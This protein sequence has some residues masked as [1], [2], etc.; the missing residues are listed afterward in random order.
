MGKRREELIRRLETMS[1]D[2]A[3]DGWSRLRD[4]VPQQPAPTQG[5]SVA[6]M[7]RTFR[8][9]AYAAIAVAVLV[10]GTVAMVRF[11][12]RP[13]DLDFVAD[14][15][16]AVRNGTL[17]LNRTGPSDGR[18]GMPPDAETLELALPDIDAYFGRAPIPALPD[19]YSA[20]SKTLSAIIFRNGTIFQMGGI[21]YSKDPADP[22]AARVFFDL[23]DQGELPLADCT[24]G[25]GKTSTLDGV[26]MLLGIETVDEGDGSG[27]YD[28]YTAQFVAN[29]IGYRVRGIRVSASEFLDILSA[30][31]KG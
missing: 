13:A 8:I 31:V 23:N 20:D 18:I 6:P 16:L 7:K 29:G 30:V 5:R 3:P 10:L 26:E 15:T 1:R 27:P 12:P 25:G 2:E 19:G 4:R 9:S 22:K 28:V 21:A 11:A 24:F 14:Q 17:Y